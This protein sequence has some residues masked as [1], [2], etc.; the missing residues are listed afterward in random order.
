MNIE[1]KGVTK[2]FGSNYVLRGVDFDLKAGEVHA[3]MGENGAG[4]STL[5]NIM[6]G[7]HKKDEG[8][9]FID[10]KELLFDSPKAA[11]N[12]GISFIHQEMI[13][14]PEMTVLENL[15]MGKEMK[16]SFGWIKTKDMQNKADNIFRELGIQIDFDKQM[17][18]LSVGQQQLVEIAKTLMND[19]EV[20]IMD[21]PTAALTDREIELLFKIMNQL[22]ER[23]VAIVYISHR[24]EEI[25]KISDRVTVMRDG[26]SISTKPT[27]ETNYDEIVRQMVGRDLEDYYPTIESEKG[28]VILEVKGLSRSNLF[29][30]ISFKLHSGEILGFSGLMGSGRTEIMRGIFGIDRLEKGDIFL[31]GEKVELK[32]PNDAISKGIGF[33]TENRKDE[34]LFLDFSI[35][36]NISMTAFEEFS[37]YG[38][39]NRKEETDFV[40][41][42]IKRLTV[43]TT[44]MELP[45]SALSGGNQQKVVLAK[46][47]GAGS[48]VLIL[49]EP[50]RGVD[51]GAKKEIY[52]LMK[53]LTERG[54]GIIMVSSDLPEV[55]GVSDRVIVV[56]E[57]KIAGELSKESLSEEKIMTLATGGS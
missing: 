37:K 9:I 11:E 38:W 36:D 23:N 6:T 27:K 44:D 16:T 47:I 17:K 42:L 5:M 28:E 2:S 32:T 52:S 55:I 50:T 3:L 15:F 30:E 35:R 56:H 48:K 45:A 20:I 33:L 19:T 39:I 49:D 54:V 1:M 51:V 7:L 21:E 31:E 46:W 40:D 13:T 8:Q 10:G 43:K 34:G 14:W 26:I 53:E 22:K 18:T 24:M 12:Y 57:G 25:F 4:K 41:L 29:N